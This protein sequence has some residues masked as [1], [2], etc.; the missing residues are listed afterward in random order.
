VT[1]LGTLN[2]AVAL[3]CFPG[4]ELTLWFY[5]E[6]KIRLRIMDENG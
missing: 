3:E 4:F 2:E 5:M 1:S 6:L